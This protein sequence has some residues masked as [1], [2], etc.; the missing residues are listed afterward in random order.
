MRATLV[1]ACTVALSA[2]LASP[3][4]AAPTGEGIA[5]ESND[6]V[7]TFASLGVVLGFVVL[8]IV[9]SVIQGRLEHRKDERKA[10][11]AAQR[12]GW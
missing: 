7:V 5:G 12:I 9:A 8:V 2:V 10:A 4:L 6:K 11:R 3:A 1:I